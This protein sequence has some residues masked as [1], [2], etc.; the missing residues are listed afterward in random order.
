VSVPVPGGASYVVDAGLE[1]ELIYGHGFELP[2]FAAFP[3]LEDD[4]GRAVLA[5]YYTD[6]AA[7]ATKAGAGLMLTA[8]TWRANAAW[9]EV[10]GYDAAALDRVNREGIAFMRELAGQWPDLDIAV[11]GVVGPLGDAYTASPDKDASLFRGQL[12][13]FL[14]AGADLADALTFPSAGEAVGLVRAANEVGLPVGVSFTVETDGA[15]P[16]GTALASAVARVRAEGEVAYFGINCAHPTHIA[17]A[18]VA[19]DW[20]DH[21]AQ[22]R[23]NA[24]T[25]THGELDV[26]SELDAGDVAE[27][28]STFDALRVTLPRLSVV[29]GCCGTGSHHVA[30][31]WGV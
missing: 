21:I 25:K 10:I 19:G 30:A 13:S 7:I 18:L 3:L 24:S 29:G 8:P 31:L 22:I 4:H 20:V 5:D 27:L 12:E 15:L 9:G 2:E 11:A 17:P 26:M 23:P 16:D 28:A 14:E 6:F 1:T